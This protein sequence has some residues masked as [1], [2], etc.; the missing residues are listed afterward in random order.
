VALAA[1]R[2]GGC[3]RATRRSRHAGART[4]PSASTAAEVVRWSSFCCALVPVVLLLCGS[5]VAGALGTAGG[6]AAVTV[7]CRMLLRRADRGARPVHAPVHDRRHMLSGP[8]LPAPAARAARHG[9]AHAGAHR[10]T[11]G[12]RRSAR[13]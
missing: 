3:H 2:E 9:R 1:R 4:T 5:S 7:A 11:P 12:H 8:T 10:S 13:G 6:L